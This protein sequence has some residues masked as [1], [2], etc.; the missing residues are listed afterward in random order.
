MKHILP[1][2]I[3]AIGFTACKEAE[4]TP[5]ISE[6]DTQVIQ[7]TVA[8]AL[9][10]RN[11]GVITELYDVTNALKFGAP[12]MGS[13]QNERPPRPGQGNERNYSRTYDPAT[14][15]HVISFDHSIT[16]PNISKSMSVYQE[17]IFTNPDGAF[18]QFPGRQEVATTA[19]VGRRE[20]SITTPNSTSQDTRRAQWT[21][22]GLQRSSS[23]IVL[24]GTQSNSGTMSVTLRDGNTA[25][26]EFSMALTFVDVNID[27][28]YQTDSKLEDKVSGTITFEHTMK[29][30]LPTGEIREKTSTGS[31]ELS[32]DGRALLRIMGI[33]A[34]F[35]I[36]LATGDVE[37]GS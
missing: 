11:D 35:R 17:Y 6:E 1:L 36:N 7:T 37:S 14:G 23:V 27:K 5:A 26:R 2:L 32:G 34:L 18:V 10:D 12:I 20:G 24:N 16:M 9:A 3:L 31:I 28:A 21:M 29:H 33:R 30:T 25:A 19:Y 8:Q 15:K 4:K 22:T 13:V